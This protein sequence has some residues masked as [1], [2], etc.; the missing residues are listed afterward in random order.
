VIFLR[1]RP[2]IDPKRIG[3]A[4]NSQA[5]WILPLA[6]RDLGDIAFMV[7]HSGPVCTV[8]EE[9]FYS[10]LV[11][12]NTT[13]RNEEANRRMS[14]YHGPSGY[15][16]V[17]VLEAVRTPT[18]WLLCLDDRSIPVQLTLRNLEKLKASGHPFEWRTYEGLDHG[19]GPQIWPDIAQWVAKFK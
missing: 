4:G 7:L 2:E 15:D 10:D 18:L 14:E 17:P 19:L 5:G 9:M 12:N 6:A 13:A 16:P 3:L 8:G 1:T 11:E